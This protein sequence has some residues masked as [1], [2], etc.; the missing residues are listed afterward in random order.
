MSNYS[1]GIFYFSGTGNTKIIANLFKKELENNGADVNVTAIEDIFKKKVHFSIRK[2]DIIGLGHPVHAFSA[3]K[4]FF[5]FISGLPNVKNKKTFMFKTSG[6]PFC[7]GGGTTLVR[8]KLERKGY[9]VFHEYLIV[10]PSN[11]VIKYEDELVKQ[12]YNVAIIKIKNMSKEILVGKVKLQ[13]NNFFLRIGTY[14]FNTMERIGVKYLGSYLKTSD[15]CIL[16]EKCIKNCPTRNISKEDNKIKFSKNCTFCMRCIY[17]CPNRAITIRYFNFFVI[18][19]GYNIQRIIY[20][21]N[22]KGNYVSS[23]T[24]GFFKHFYSYLIED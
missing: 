7:N 13:K 2:Y 24:K 5:D 6:D 17:N 12:L 4:I 11:V 9:R 22:V 8:K 20:D 15:S 16:C 1:I 14:L 3:P 18:K 23:K 19:E 10:M 21:P